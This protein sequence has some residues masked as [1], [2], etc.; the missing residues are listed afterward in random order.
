MTFRNI[1]ATGVKILTVMLK[2]L[3]REGP[4]TWAKAWGDALDSFLKFCIQ[5]TVGI[6]LDFPK[7]AKD[8][9]SEYY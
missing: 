8:S 3:Q 1:L 2:E 4:D 7:N 5:K 6:T 9:R